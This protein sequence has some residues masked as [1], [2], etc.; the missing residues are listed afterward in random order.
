MRD[1]GRLALKKERIFSNYVN[2]LVIGR[3]RW[4]ESAGVK[5]DDYKGLAT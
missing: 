3:D 5:K 4:F 1:L 2:R